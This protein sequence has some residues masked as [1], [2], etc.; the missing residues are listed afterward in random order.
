MDFYKFILKSTVKYSN[1]KIWWR[2]S[3]N[4]Q[5]RLFSIICNCVLAGA[6]MKE[7]HIFLHLY[8]FADLFPSVA[9]LRPSNHSC[10]LSFG[11]V[12]LPQAWPL[13]VLLWLLVDQVG[14]YDFLLVNELALCCGEKERNPFLFHSLLSQCSLM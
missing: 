8:S 10:Y 11:D 2:S 13:W 9:H 6:E 5:F 3:P 12:A 1:L 4:S 14:W 7:E